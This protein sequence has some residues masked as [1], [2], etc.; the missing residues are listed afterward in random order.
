MRGKDKSREPRG[1]A[2]RF[3][4]DRKKPIPRKG[5]VAEV[6]RKSTQSRRSDA[7]G[8]ARRLL[9]ETGSLPS[10]YE[11]TRVVLTP[12]DPHLVNVRWD[13][14]PREAERARRRSLSGK[15][16][17]LPVLRL[18]ET[19]PGLA[20]A[21]EPRDH[22]DVEIDL[23]AGNWYIPLWHGG[24]TYFAEI[25]FR[26][27][28]GAFYPLARSNTAEVPPEA[29]LE[30]DD[31][32]HLVVIG[33]ENT[34]E[35]FE[36]QPPSAP[37][38]ERKAMSEIPGPKPSDEVTGASPPSE[39]DP[40]MPPSKKGVPPVVLKWQRPISFSW[41]LPEGQIPH[42]TPEALKAPE[43]EEAS[44]LSAQAEEAFEAGVSS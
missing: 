21:R 29:P 5:A 17:S 3:P 38:P 32:R 14:N 20:D 18:F 22:F 13:L 34:I 6:A 41:G 26:S 19:A 16:S 8:S 7:G 35:I 23:R 1:V 10:M 36:L 24:K 28:G 40:G 12:I 11:E 30:H 25:G 39:R 44:D 2:K 15:R 4:A 31:E 9:E 42:L 27:A 43:G 37:P 33:E